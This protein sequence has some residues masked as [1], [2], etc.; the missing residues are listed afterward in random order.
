M[1]SVT[2]LTHLALSESLTLPSPGAKPESWRQPCDRVLTSLEAFSQG[3]SGK[4]R[5]F[6]EHGDKAGVE[7]LSTNCIACLAHLA[8]LSEVVGRTDPVSRIEMYD[9]CDSALR[10]LG[11]LTSE[12]CLDEYTYLDLLLGVRSRFVLLLDGDGSNQKLGV[13][14]LEEIA[15]DLRRPDRGPLSRRERHVAALPAGSRREV[16]RLSE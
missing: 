12:L 11:T 1:V 6:R 13:G 10:R 2:R 3:L 7:T 15:T 5:R 4:I 8:I 14:L 9:R 16:F